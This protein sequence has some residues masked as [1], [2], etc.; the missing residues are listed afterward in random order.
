MP[1]F[2][3]VREQLLRAG[4]APRHVRRYIA[5]LREHLA[6]L[7]AQE[8]ATG[9]DP[10]AAALRARSLL[11]SDAQLAET[12]LRTAP[13]SLAARAPWSV[14]VVLPVALLVL[15]TLAIN[16]SMFQLL[17][18]M[19][20]LAHAA[21]PAGYQALISAAGFL[22]S[23]LVG[24]L[25]ACLCIMVALRQR[26]ASRWV[27][28]GLA[29][30]ALLSGPLGFQMHVAADGGQTFSAAR[31]LYQHGRPDLGATLGAAL[32]RSLVLFGVAALAYRLLRQRLR[33]AQE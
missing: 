7:T 17:W 26:L 28:A 5:E 27:W 25:L 1:P 20:D 32:L 23:Y 31:I 21:M 22:T 12:M 6:D 4:I 8:R 3:P 29:L 19:R 9:L 13:R 16:R 24:P 10:A 15:A 30:I 33:P 18:P 2:E 11:G 14:F